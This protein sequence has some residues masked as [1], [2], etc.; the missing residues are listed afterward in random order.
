MNDTMLSI[1]RTN[2]DMNRLLEKISANTDIHEQPYT[3]TS[4]FSD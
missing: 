1:S 4:W 3:Q 2:Y